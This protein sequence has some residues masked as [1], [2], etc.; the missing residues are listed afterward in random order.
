MDRRVV[1]QEGRGQTQVGMQSPALPKTLQP[2]RAPIP[3]PGASQG[4]PAAQ[5]P[6]EEM[7]GRRTRHCTSHGGPSDTGPPPCTPGRRLLLFPP[8]RSALDR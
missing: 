8:A 5:V 2:V 4:S 1:L 7:Q 3:V 6:S